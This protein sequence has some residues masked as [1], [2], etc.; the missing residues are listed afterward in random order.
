MKN[1]SLKNR[2]FASLIIL[3][4]AL[5][6]VSCEKETDIVPTI[7]DT[8]LTYKSTCNVTVS[9][10]SITGCCF[11]F[12][13]Q[14]A[15]NMSWTMDFGDGVVVRGAGDGV[16]SHCYPDGEAYNVTF[17]CGG[18][19]QQSIKGNCKDSVKE[20]IPYTAYFD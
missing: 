11:D 18:I 9:A 6:M 12:K 19:S 8:T 20:R 1:L 3:S 14:G 4:L 5:L 2:F 7:N 16:L 10:T 13:I 17:E 15:T